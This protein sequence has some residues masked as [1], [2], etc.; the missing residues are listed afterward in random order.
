MHSYLIVIYNQSVFESPTYQT[1][2][3]MIEAYPHEAELHIWDDSPE[4][5]HKEQIK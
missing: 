3:A 4:P 1:L 2:L 5:Q